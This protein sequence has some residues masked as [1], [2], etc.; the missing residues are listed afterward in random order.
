MN[1]DVINGRLI[2]ERLRMMRRDARGYPV[3]WF[4]HWA[5]DKPDFRIIGAAKVE[6]A[7]KRNVCWICG[8]PLARNRAFVIGPLTAISRYHAEPPCHREC[9]VFAAEVCPFLSKPRMRRNDNNMPAE[10]QKLPG[11]MVLHNPGVCCVWI[12]RDYRV[13]PVDSGVLFHLNDPIETLWFSNGRAAERGEVVNAMDRGLPILIDEAK[14]DS[15]EAVQ[16]LLQAINRM[17]Q[18]L[19]SGGHDGEPGS[20]A[21]GHADAA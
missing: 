8:G 16:A 4:V 7:I 20:A 11:N 2:P 1:K 10:T 17:R 15:D 9:G 19:P 12:T 6:I 13:V 5:D 21:K 3:P 18:Y 14:Q